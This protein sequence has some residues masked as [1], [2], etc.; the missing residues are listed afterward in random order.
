M[1]PAKSFANWK[2]QGFKLLQ[3]VPI[4]RLNNSKCI[5]RPKI[6]LRTQSK[7]CYFLFVKSRW[8]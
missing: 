4:A 2:S 8:S 7:E 5:N 6:Y 3:S 1:K